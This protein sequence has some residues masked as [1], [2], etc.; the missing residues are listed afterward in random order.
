MSRL[1][2]MLV[3]LSP[4]SF[5]Q[6][7]AGSQT[8]PGTIDMRANAA[9]RSRERARRAREAEENS[10]LRAASIVISELREGI[11]TV[12]GTDDEV[13][14]ITGANFSDTTAFKFFS[15]GQNISEH[16]FRAKFTTV[17]LTNGRETWEGTPTEGWWLQ[18]G[19]EVTSE[20]CCTSLEQ[21]RDYCKAWAAGTGHARI[22]Y[23]HS[24]AGGPNAS[25]GYCPRFLVNNTDGITPAEK[26]KAEAVI[27]QD[28]ARA[29]E[30]FNAKRCSAQ[31][32]RPVSEQNADPT[33][34][35]RYQQR[36]IEQK[37]QTERQIKEGELRQKEHDQAISRLGIREG[38]PQA[39]VKAQLAADG[40]KMPWQCA[41]NWSQNV[42]VSISGDWEWIATCSTERVRRDGDID[43]VQ[44]FFS[45]YRRVRYVNA[46]TGAGSLGDQ[47]T[48]KLLLINYTGK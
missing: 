4:L 12:S 3:I 17:R 37:K 34:I 28:N 24:Y 38:Q 39:E 9:N 44:V 6:A 19:T 29:A 32:P 11:V 43:R 23:N 2:I 8:E 45:V 48:D 18:T 1:A 47:K 27:A 21:E 5:V 26:Q 22:S 13:L 41:G 16:Y 30:D 46:D 35:A 10:Y 7:Q 36:E 40:F 42:G 25:G 33:C 31:D 14:V 20:L 15:P